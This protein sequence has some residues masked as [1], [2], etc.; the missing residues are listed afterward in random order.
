M[1]P[2]ATAAP[3]GGGMNAGELAASIATRHAEPRHDDEG[4]FGVPA[5]PS[6]ACSANG[7]P[8]AGGIITGG[9]RSCWAHFGIGF[10]HH[11]RITAWLRRRPVLVEALSIH[12]GTTWAAMEALGARLTAAGLGEFAP[13]PI[14]LEHEG[15]GRHGEGLKVER[16]ERGSPRLYRYRL[17]ALVSQ[18]LDD[19]KG[20]EL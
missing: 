20:L 17:R 8:L 3:N 1:A 10:A 9:S 6:W 14:T 4:G 18:A 5:R 16:D 13:R 15:Y 7:C 19:S 2:G 12:D 11:D